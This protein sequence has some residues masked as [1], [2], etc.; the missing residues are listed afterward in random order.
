MKK[1]LRIL[2]PLQY[3]EAIRDYCV[4]IYRPHLPH[5]ELSASFLLHAQTSTVSDYD[6]AQNAPW[7]LKSIQA[8]IRDGC[9]GVFIDVAFDT[10]LTAAKSLADIPVVGALEAAVAMARNL[11]HRF[12]IL[13]IN[14]EEVPVNQRLARE[15]SFAA[16]LVSVEP[17]DIPVMQLRADPKLTVAR[18]TEAG[19]KAVARGASAIILGC[20]AMSWATAELQACLPV[21]VLD[22][23]LIGL[24]TLDVLVELRLKQSKLEFISPSGLVPLSEEE[25]LR[26][27]QGTFAIH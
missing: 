12:S 11:C 19:Q 8:A 17:I 27:R 4:Q 2:L 22:T 24:Y 6:Q 3:N 7:V 13:A 25:Y 23:S 18:L 20:T 15:Y 16:E 14:D 10:A 26:I 9:H 1:H 5:T 21:P